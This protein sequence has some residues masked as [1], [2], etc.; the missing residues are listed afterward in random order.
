MENK[1]VEMS[2][3]AMGILN[4]LDNVQN[5]TVLFSFKRIMKNEIE[6]KTERWV[7]G[8]CHGADFCLMLDNIID[9]IRFFEKLY[10]K[11][12]GV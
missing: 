10:M 4:E 3:K 5:K 2:K 11:E 6:R 9:V 1:T 8:E 7:S 12:M